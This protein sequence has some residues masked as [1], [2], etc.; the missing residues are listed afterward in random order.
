MAVFPAQLS[1]QTSNLK[2]SFVGRRTASLLFLST[3]KYSFCGKKAQKIYFK[4]D[5]NSVEYPLYGQ[6]FPRYY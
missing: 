4:V 2:N 1:S 5:I 6:L 3:T